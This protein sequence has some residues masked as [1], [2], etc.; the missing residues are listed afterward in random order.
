MSITTNRWSRIVPETDRADR[1]EIRRTCLPNW[2]L[3]SLA[4]F[5][6]TPLTLSLLSTH[7]LLEP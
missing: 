1:G 4:Y 7:R 5:R 3:R 2:L 6:F